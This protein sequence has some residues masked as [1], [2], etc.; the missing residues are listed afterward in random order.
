MGLRRGRVARLVLLV[1]AV[2]TVGYGLDL[3][4]LPER[5]CSARFV[6]AAIDGYRATL[7]PLMPRLGLRCRFVPTCSEYGRAVVASDGGG[8][9]VVR[10]ALRILRCGP[11]TPAGTVDPP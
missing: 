3:L 9:R 1:A 11:W 8:K 10:A 5:Q 2:V 6:L 7:S 4:R